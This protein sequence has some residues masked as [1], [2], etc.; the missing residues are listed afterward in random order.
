MALPNASVIRKSNPEA[1]PIEG[2]DNYSGL[3]FFGNVAS[4]SLTT[5][6]N[7]R[8]LRS[9]LDAESVGIDYSY[10]DETKATCTLTCTVTGADNDTANFKITDY[11]GVVDLGT[12]VRT[13]ASSTPTLAATAAAAAINS[14]S[15]IHGYTATSAAAV[16]T[17][18]APAG[19]GVSLNTLS[20]DVTVTGTA[21]FNRTPFTGGLSSIKAAWRYHIDMV[22]NKNPDA[23]LH[24]GVYP[25]PTVNNFNEVENLALFYNGQIKKIGV[26]AEHINTIAKSD[27]EA[28]QTVINR[29]R[30]ND[31]PVSCIYTANLRSVTDLNT[32]LNLNTVNAESVMVVISGDASPQS[33]G[34]ELHNT[35]NKSISD[36]GAFIGMKSKGKVNNAIS[37]VSLFNFSDGVNNESLMFSNGQLYRNTPISQLNLLDDY[38]YVFLRKF[39]A[40]NRLTGSYANRDNN[41][42]NI[43]NE[44]NRGFMVDV[45]NKASR[46]LREV[47]LQSLSADI[48]L[49]ADGTLQSWQA[50]SLKALGDD[51]LANMISAQEISAGEVTIDP[52]QNIRATNKLVVKANLV[53]NG[54]A[55]DIQIELGYV[56]NL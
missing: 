44:Y 27:L 8:L 5:L 50:Q 52:T 13:A 22:F 33:K 11:K 49:N 9:P 34:W 7:K 31:S 37:N 3:V 18:T 41:A 2:N 56:P 25:V 42:T 35:H 26:F 4:T 46:I 14:Q 17:I 20:V 40:T 16:V 54:V 10:S 15:Y 48:F 23:Y 29:L 36:L 43:S 32:M 45:Y 28:L 38:R 19:K 1:T 12:Y 6:S 24:I 30:D 53:R 55:E 47:Y 51:G 39:N 21:S